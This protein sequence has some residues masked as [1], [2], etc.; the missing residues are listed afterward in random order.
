MPVAIE[1]KGKSMARLCWTVCGA[2]LSAVLASCVAPP[3]LVGDAATLRSAT[4]MSCADLG[5]GS[6]IGDAVVMAAEPV[7]GGAYTAIDGAKYADLP[8]FCRVLALA[9]PHPSSRVLIEIW[10]PEPD[11]WNGKFFG[12][13]NGGAAGRVSSAGLAGGLRRGFATANTDLG[14]YPAGISGVGFNFGDGHPEMLKD[15]GHRATHA[16]TVVAK[17]VIDRFYGRPATKSLFAGCSTGGQQA[18]MEAQ[19]YPEDYDGIIAGAPA[20]NRTHLHVR[21][22]ALRQ[23]GSQPDAALPQRVLKLWKEAFLS[24]CVGRDG[25]APGDDFLTNPLHCKASPRALLCKPGESE[26]ECLTEPQVRSLEAIYDGTRNPRTNEL[27][28][29]ADVIGAETW[30]AFLYGDT[31]VAR[32]FDVT[33]WVL[34]ADRSAASFDFDRDVAALDEKFAPDV[35]AMNHDLSRFADR[36]GKL[37]MFHGW[38]DGAIGALDS[39]D[40]FQRVKAS[41]RDTA[42]FAR[43]FLAPGMSHCAGGPGPGQF[44]QQ[45][46]APLAQDPTPENDLIL[47]LDRWTDAGPAPEAIVA[48]LGGGGERPICAYPSFARYNGSGDRK[49]ASSFTCAI[50]PRAQYERPADRYMR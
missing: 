2:A 26:A 23:L 7:A 34:P 18:L 9:R 20:H 39:I 16:M 46:D 44:G 41:G 45:A 37:I 14:T 21:F 35:N 5:N 13:G 29:V 42:A 8:P 32:N 11:R 36:G 48:R 40:Y 25:G 19:R 30:L 17:D 38:E 47:A 27:I 31:P 6:V 12:T 3:S 10:M 33:N 28:A 24:A 15:F 4:T 22:A 43:L 49:N 50:G 1:I